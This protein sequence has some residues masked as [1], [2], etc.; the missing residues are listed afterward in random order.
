[1]SIPTP[2]ASIE[3][4]SPVLSKAGRLR[5]ESPSSVYDGAFQQQPMSHHSGS[6]ELAPVLFTPYQY[7]GPT[8][9]E[10][11]V[12]FYVEHYVL[13]Y[14]DEVR[15]SSALSGQEWFGNAAAQATMAALGLAAMG[16]INNDK[17][18]QH[19]SKSQYGEALVKTNEILQDPVKNLDTAVRATV[20]LALYQ[21]RS[22]TSCY[23]AS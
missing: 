2:P 21:V 9:S 1:M 16:N 12:A 7:L 10:A 4:T 8:P 14:P 15:N 5:S 11:G 6:R 13:G 22:L 3:S 17:R 23:S 18:L 19:L 20:M